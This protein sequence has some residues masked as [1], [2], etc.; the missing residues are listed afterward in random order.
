MATLPQEMAPLPIIYE[1]RPD[2]ESCSLHMIST[3]CANSYHAD[4]ISNAAHAAILFRH[5]HGT[6]PYF[7]TPDPLTA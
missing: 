5:K 7:W 3:G 2:V 1:F 6:L 4:I